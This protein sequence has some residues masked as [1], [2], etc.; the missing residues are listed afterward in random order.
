M[1]D[2]LIHLP[3]DVMQLIRALRGAGHSAH[4]VGGCVRDSLL[5][6]TPGDWDLCT[7]ARPEQMR[8]I[9]A[10]HQLILTGE[11]HGTVA[12]VLHG[13]PYEIT[14]YRLDGDYTDHRR[15][16]AVNG[17]KLFAAFLRLL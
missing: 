8:R 4:V 3:R 12:V 16:D 1:A 2:H 14:T 6:R 17:E 7:N 10:G 15:P 5:G 11:K 9:F 13:V